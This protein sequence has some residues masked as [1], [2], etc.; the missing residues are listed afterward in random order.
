ME[1]STAIN[2]NLLS[3]RLKNSMSSK[4]EKSA[5]VE[6][7]ISNFL[8][9]K[10]IGNQK[11]ANNFREID[12]GKL[13]GLQDRMRVLL[14]QRSNA[15]KEYYKKTQRWFGSIIALEKDSFTAKLEDLNSP[16]T[17]EVASFDI[18]DVSQGDRD[19][20]GIGKNFYWSVGYYVSHDGQVKKES[21][22]RFQRLPIWDSNDIDEA[23]DSAKE[24][25][26][27]INWE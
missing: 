9:N 12:E 11:S 6:A 23:A 13:D 27:T 24:L 1:T 2:P 15:P 22:I 10:K 4:D 20:I 8:K 17:Y 26:D 7:A 19:L 3:N 25:H 14:A 16:D 21:L 5:S 18:E